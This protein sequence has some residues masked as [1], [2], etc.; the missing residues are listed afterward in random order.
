MSLKKVFLATTIVAV[1]ATISFASSSKNQ[2]TQTNLV[3]NKAKYNAE[4]ID[5]KLINGWGIATRPAGAGGHFWVA[6]SGTSFQYVGDV[7]K[8]SDA[9]LQKLHTDEIAH[10]SIPTGADDAVTTGVVFVDSK[11]S[12]NIT[13]NL[14]DGGSVSASSKFI[15]ASDGGVISA[16][17]ERKKDDGSFD[18]PLK[19]KTVIDESANGAQFFGLAI[20]SSFDKIYAANFGENPDIK[21]YDGDF[22]PVQITFDMPFDENKN[23][24]VDAGEYAPFNIQALKTPE[25]KSSIFVAY[26]KT[27]ECPE[28]EVAK[29]SC[30]K[31]EIFVGEEDTEKPGSGRIAEFTED[32][33]LVSVLNDGGKLSAPW[34]VVFAPS[35]FGALSGSFLVANFGDGT[36]SAYDYDKNEFIDYLKDQNDKPVEIE[37]IWGLVFGNGA[38]L[39]DKDALYFA[40]GPEDEEDGIFGSLRAVK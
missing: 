38:S 26:A 19:A 35:N 3:A 39:G 5:E 15:F 20:N 14:A 4:A 17:T 33:K 23:G 11:D 13:Q 18:R 6:G 10:I 7:Q 28:E 25:G 16:W 24:K 1:A 32:G 37:G 21:V 22:K 29:N 27:Q 40:A 12:F 34:G 9:K 30:A 8:S 36:I 2:Y 31:G